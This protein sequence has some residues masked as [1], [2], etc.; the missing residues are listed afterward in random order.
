MH[1]LIQFWISW[2]QIQGENDDYTQVKTSSKMPEPHWHSAQ[3][4]VDCKTV[5]VGIFFL[6][7]IETIS[8][9]ILNCHAK[10]LLCNS[11]RVEYLNAVRESDLAEIQNPLSKLFNPLTNEI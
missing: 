7:I 5:A 8:M 10:M 4:E 3:I 1:K 6:S 2:K 11:S 9:D